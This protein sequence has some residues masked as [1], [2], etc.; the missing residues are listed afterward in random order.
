MTID[1]MTA[2]LIAIV[3]ILTAALVVWAVARRRRSRHL[4][5][6]FGSE[7]DHAVQSNRSR[8][9]AEQE[10][11]AREEHAKNIRVQPLSLDQRRRFEQDWEA[12]ESR[13]VGR[14][15]AAVLDANELIQEVLRVRGYPVRDLDDATSDLS[16]HHPEVVEDLRAAR[17]VINREQPGEVS[18]EDLRQAMLHFRRLFEELVGRPPHRRDD[19]EIAI[20][21]ERELGEPRESRGDRDRLGHR[22]EREIRDRQREH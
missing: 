3:V 22:T 20:D 17:A 21:E 13:F 4:Q 11:L 19:A 15:T 6:R 2:T 16:V 9:R 7:Y 8:S 14:P 1:T 12:I 10:L 5:E 18:T